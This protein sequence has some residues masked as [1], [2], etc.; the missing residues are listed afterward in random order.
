V[1]AGVDGYARHD[2][3]AGTSVNVEFVSTNPTGPVHAGGGRWAAYG[4]ALCNLLARCG[5]EPHREFYLNDRGVQMN[6]F[7]ESLLARKRGEEP[8]RAGTT[9]STS[10][11]G[12]PSFPTAPT[13][14][15]GAT[16]G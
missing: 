10:P 4:D 9:A 7:A 3:G 14:S 8:P 2:I 11:S 13:P 5:Y 16:S 6:L 1:V 15:N 12:R